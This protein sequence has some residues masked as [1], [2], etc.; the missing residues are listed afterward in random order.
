MKY[1][2]KV[3]YTSINYRILCYYR[4]IMCTSLKNKLTRTFTQKHCISLMFL[5]KLSV[6]K[7]ERRQQVDSAF[8]RK[9][10]MTVNISHMF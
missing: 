1:K 7:V 10:T 6:G 3:K 2:I 4:Y 8:Q 9:H 5:Q